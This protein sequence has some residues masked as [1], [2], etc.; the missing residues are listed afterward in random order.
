MFDWFHE[1]GYSSQ[2]SDSAKYSVHGIFIYINKKKNP[3][4]L[5]NLCTYLTY[6][7]YIY[8]V[9]LL[10]VTIQLHLAKIGKI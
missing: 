4:S 2:P 6:V 8:F 3:L 5:I 10:S 1:I 7:N 9:K